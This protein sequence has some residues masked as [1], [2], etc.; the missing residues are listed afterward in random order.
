MSTYTSDLDIIL[1]AETAEELDTLEGVIEYAAA[2][3]RTGLVN[4]T[5]SAQRYVEQVNSQYPEQLRR[6]ILKGYQS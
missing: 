1:G 3:V 4:S 2:L 5:G 6:E